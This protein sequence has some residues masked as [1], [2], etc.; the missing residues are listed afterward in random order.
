ML[1]SKSLTERIYNIII[2]D[3]C[4]LNRMNQNNKFNH[5]Y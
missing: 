2:I 5:F 1:N 3:I 4:L